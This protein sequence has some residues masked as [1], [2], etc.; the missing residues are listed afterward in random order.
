MLGSSFLSPIPVKLV[1]ISNTRLFLQVISCC[2]RT[3]TSTKD[4]LF[5]SFDLPKLN[6]SMSPTLSSR[7]LPFDL[8][9]VGHSSPVMGSTPIVYLPRPSRMALSC[10]SGLTSIPS[11]WEEAVHASMSPVS[12]MSKVENNNFNFNN[13]AQMAECAQTLC[14]LN[15]APVAVAPIFP[16]RRPSSIEFP[17]PSSYSQKEP[18]FLPFLAGPQTNRAWS[19][20]RSKRFRVSSDTSSVADLSCFELKSAEPSIDHCPPS[21]MSVVSRVHSVSP[22]LG[23]L[24]SPVSSLTSDQTPHSKRMRL[25][26]HACPTCQKTFDRPSTL[27]LHLNSHTGNK[28]FCCAHSGCQAAFSVS[29]NRNRHEK[30][31]RYPKPSL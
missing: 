10:A 12:P 20:S 30:T 6:T 17:S 3:T 28:P 9:S 4:F 29:S 27:R 13:D 19:H 7:Q 21:P 23:S 16:S 15:R 25:K 22:S 31:C 5:A 26:S 8:P 14:A 2:L 11:T 1:E 18:K 24:P